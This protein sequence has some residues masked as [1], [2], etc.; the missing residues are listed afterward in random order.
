MR[1]FRFTPF[2]IA[3]MAI[4]GISLFLPFLP[5][6]SDNNGSYS[7]IFIGTYIQ[8]VDIA[9]GLSVLLI[10]LIWVSQCL[11]IPSLILYFIRKQH[12]PV[13][14]PILSSLLMLISSLAVIITQFPKITAIPFI[15]GILALSDIIF[16][17]LIKKAR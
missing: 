5:W 14:L 15:A 16:V 11:A 3:S 17:V 9:L 1:K 12:A 13:I 7:I 10:L 4:L 6:L 8:N 2:L